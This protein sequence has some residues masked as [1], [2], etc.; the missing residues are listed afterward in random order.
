MHDS[1]LALGQAFFTAYLPGPATLLDVGSQEI[2]YSLRRFAPAGIAYVGVDITAGQGVDIVLEDPHVLPF[3]DQSFDAVVTTSCFEHDS[4]FWVSFLEILRVTRPGG[5]VYINAPSNGWYHTYPR[6]N[7]RFYP[8]AGLTLQDW[9]RRQ[10]YEVTLA[11]SFISRR[12]RD[13]WNDFVA[14][15][16][17]GP[18]DVPH[19]Y[20]SDI[21]TQVM[22]LRRGAVAEVQNYSWGSEDQQLVD[23]L[24]KELAAKDQTIAE[25]CELLARQEEA[26]AG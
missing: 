2:K 26:V 21:Y 10:G 1:A 20:I 7:W 25:L 16:R 22:N 11:E 18:D 6:D 19:D 3:A 4:M 5:Y 8:D 24:R 15:F 13:I 17:N 9:G 23:A 12:R 14:V